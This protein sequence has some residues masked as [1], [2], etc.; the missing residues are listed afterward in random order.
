M[1]STSIAAYRIHFTTEIPPNITV[2]TIAAQFVAVFSQRR[3][4]SIA[5][6][7]GLNGLCFR[8]KKWL[9]VTPDAPAPSRLRLMPQSISHVAAEPITNRN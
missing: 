4:D 7:V 1:F 2:P 5:K 6:S 8:I 9:S 3:F